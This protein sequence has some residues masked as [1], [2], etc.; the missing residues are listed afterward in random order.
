SRTGLGQAD[1]PVPGDAALASPPAGASG[2]PQVLMLPAHHR[3]AL[4][5]AC[6]PTAT[7]SSSPRQPRVRA[8]LPSPI[9][10]EATRQRKWML[11][12]VAMTIAAGHAGQAWSWGATGHYLISSMAVAAL[13]DDVPAFLRTEEMPQIMGTLGR[14][15]DRSKGSGPTHDMERDP[16]HFVDI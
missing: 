14:E 2:R 16:G 4:S 10:K 8:S 1:A 15:A 7:Q 5:A 3:S 11:A 9:A 12:V 13:P 6:H